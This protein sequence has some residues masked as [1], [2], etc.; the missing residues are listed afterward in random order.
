MKDVKA[1]FFLQQEMHEILFSRIVVPTTT[2]KQV[3]TMVQKEI[4]G[5]TWVFTVKLQALRQEF[6]TMIMKHNKAV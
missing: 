3:W 6:E 5:P 4:Q 1:L 2:S